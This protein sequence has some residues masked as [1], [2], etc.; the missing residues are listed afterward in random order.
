[1]SESLLCCPYCHGD[2]DEHFKCN[3]CELQYRYEHNIYYFYNAQ[4]EHWKKVSSIVNKVYVKNLPGTD[5]DYDWFMQPLVSHAYPYMIEG[6]TI[7]SNANGA[8]LNYTYEI[9]E[10]RLFNDDHLPVLNIGSSDC[11]EAYFFARYKPVIALNVLEHVRWLW[12]DYKNGIT[13]VV[14]DGMYL[15]IKDE[16]VGIIF[17]CSTYHHMEDK[18]RALKEWSRVLVPGGVLVAIGERYTEPDR[19]DYLLHEGEYFYTYEEAQETF[20]KSDFRSLGLFPMS[21][22]DNMQCKTALQLTEPGTEQN[23]ILVGVK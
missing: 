14:G 15:P 11:W 8:M 22:S 16:A 10:G 7:S 13:R 19:K 6:A 20:S 2:L 5:I 23:W 18:D 9:L 1:M 17:M 4:A 12:P 21:Y 3:L